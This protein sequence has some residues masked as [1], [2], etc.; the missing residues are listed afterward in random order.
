MPSPVSVQTT[1]AALMRRG[2]GSHESGCQ[3][4]GHS[5][6]LS[7]RV[8]PQRSPQACGF[9]A[10]LHL[11][12][13]PPHAPSPE[14]V[15][16]PAPGGLSRISLLVSL[17]P[18]PHTPGPGPPRCRHLPT[19]AGGQ[20]GLRSEG[21]CPALFSPAPPAPGYTSGHSASSFS[22]SPR[23]ESQWWRRRPPSPLPGVGE[24][25]ACCCRRDSQ[26]G[27]CVPHEFPGS[28]LGEVGWCGHLGQPLSCRRGP[29]RI[30]SPC[31]ELRGAAWRTPSVPQAGGGSAVQHWATT[32]SAVLCTQMSILPASGS[33]F[34]PSLSKLQPHPRCHQESAPLCATCPGPSVTSDAPL[35]PVRARTPLKGHSCLTGAGA[36][37][38]PTQDTVTDSTPVWAGLGRCRPG[39]GSG[40]AAE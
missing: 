18:C 39:L 5:L 15:S 23:P 19:W 37:L 10:G 25:R 16:P 34:C 22:K 17:V 11:A 20:L 21:S 35:S 31:A 4:R 30:R 24:G 12:A 13:P 32:N 3:S 8:L 7:E 14:D 6:Q 26:E 36:R 29:G 28:P 38:P 33:T 27:L 1:F 9:C 40:C 2:P